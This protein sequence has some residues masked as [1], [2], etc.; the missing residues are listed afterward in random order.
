M[1]SVL[2]CKIHLIRLEL[3][4]HLGFTWYLGVAE[5]VGI[6]FHCYKGKIQDVTPP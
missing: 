3:Q 5:H 6:A 1:I 4:V 2:L